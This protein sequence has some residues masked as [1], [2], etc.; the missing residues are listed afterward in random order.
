[1][2]GIATKAAI[3]EFDN[4]KRKVKNYLSG[5]FR[6][7]REIDLKHQLISELYILNKSLD[8]TKC[9]EARQQL[10]MLRDS[11]V[12]DVTHLLVSK[13]NIK[14][15]IN[16]IGNDTV[17]LVLEARYISGLSWEEVAK[18][19]HYSNMHVMRLADRGYQLLADNPVDLWYN[20][21]P[22]PN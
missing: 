8:G 4:N 12:K 6:S 7:E 17:R 2:T 9:A 5:T 15:A 20:E 11:Y 13:N 19:L 16:R 21:S 1:M 14:K 3:Q 18:V 22:R 10:K